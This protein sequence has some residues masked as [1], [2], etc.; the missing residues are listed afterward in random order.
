[1]QQTLW[2]KCVREAEFLAETA[3]GEGGVLGAAR[4]R[5]ARAPH[6][7]HRRPRQR[8][9]RVAE[10][11]PVRELCVALDGC[12]QSC[13]RAEKG[14]EPPEERLVL[15]WV[16]R[17]VCE[18]HAVQCGV[19]SLVPNVVHDLRPGVSGQVCVCVCVCRTGG[20]E[21]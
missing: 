16:P 21:G 19:R 13:V 2:F 20:K 18:R 15:W 9:A 14:A 12:R 4:G 3:G 10:R 7:P 6:R 17:A 1:M 5:R 8:P 11:D